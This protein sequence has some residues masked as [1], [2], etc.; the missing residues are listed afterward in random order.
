MAEDR[1]KPTDTTMLADDTVVRMN[2]QRLMVQDSLRQQTGMS[3]IA[4]ERDIEEEPKADFAEEAQHGQGL[5]EHPFLD[6][7]QYDGID[8]SVNPAPPL[9]DADARREYDNARNEQQLQ[10]QLK[11]GLQPGKSFDP[12]PSGP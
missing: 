5:Q 12:K 1:R 7:Q 8:P 4:R 9:S 2:K 3:V 10:H 6:K 11:L